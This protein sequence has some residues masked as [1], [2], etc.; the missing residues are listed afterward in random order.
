MWQPKTFSVSNDPVS[1]AWLAGL[2]E[3]EACFSI[4]SNGGIG[5]QLG[6]TDEDVIKRVSILLGTRYHK[7]APSTKGHKPVYVLCVLSAKAAYYM[8]QVLPHMGDRR[9]EKIK[10]C[11][12]S[13]ENMIATK[14]AGIRAMSKVSDEVL[15]ETYKQYREVKSLRSI[16]RSLGVAHTTVLARLVALGEHT[17]TRVSSRA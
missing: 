4:Y 12:A 5:I 3:G 10:K 17:K 9:A 1:I 15:V 7:A 6:M 8:G 2:L 16:A 14:Q 11:L 13:Y